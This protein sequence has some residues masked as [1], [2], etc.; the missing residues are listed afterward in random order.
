[1]KTKLSKTAKTGLVALSL[2]V[3]GGAIYGVTKIMDDVIQI[4]EDKDD[5]KDMI[6][7]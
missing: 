2:I 7:I 4:E 1:M 6:G 3:I 5:L